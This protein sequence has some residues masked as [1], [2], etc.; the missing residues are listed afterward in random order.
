MDQDI[1]DEMERAVLAIGAHQ[2]QSFVLAA[3]LIEG[4]HRLDPEMTIPEIAKQLRALSD[5]MKRNLKT[6]D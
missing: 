6:G 2:A 3:D 4:L 1:K 5:E